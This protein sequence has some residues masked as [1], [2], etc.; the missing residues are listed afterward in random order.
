MK[1]IVYVK[2]V[3][4]KQNK[5]KSLRG[6][7]IVCGSTIREVVARIKKSAEDGFVLA[8]VVSLDEIVELTSD[9]QVIIGVKEFY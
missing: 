1:L 6:G 8:T 5:R 2:P 3:D 4:F 7:K 9:G